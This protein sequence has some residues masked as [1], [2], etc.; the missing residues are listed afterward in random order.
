VGDGSVR[1]VAMV[2]GRLG[3]LGFGGPAAHIAM[4]R[5]ELVQRRG[6]VDEREFLDLLAATNLIPG[7]NSTELAIHLGARRAGWRGLLA[8]GVAF[9]APAVALVSL[10]A[11]LYARYGTEP[12]V[13]DVR[14]G[15]LPVIIAIVAYALVGL[16]RTALNSRLALVVAVAACAGFLL[17]IHELLLLVAAGGLSL[18]WAQRNRLARWRPPPLAAFALLWSAPWAINLPRPGVTSTTGR[19][20]SLGRLF[21]VFVEIGSVLYGSGYVLLAFLDRNLVTD[22]GWLTRQQ[23]L[24]AV[25]VGQITPGPL[26]ST[27]TFVGWQIDGPKGAAV[28]TLGIFLPSFVFVAALGPVVRWSRRHDSARSFLYGVTAASLGLMAG[29]LV[30][31]ADVALVDPATVVVAVVALAV[32]VRTGINSAWLVLAG[33]AL[34]ALHTVS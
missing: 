1:E 15:V 23:L 20:V 33:L 19:A 6:W 27:A 30:Q 12:A 25:A 24:D 11:W 7:P 16:G 4:M 29:V 10:L 2:F 31:L 14:Y 8:A 34:G 9:I 32:L 28:A 5:E 13:V 21:A 3:V 18:G 17:E 22:L 26:F